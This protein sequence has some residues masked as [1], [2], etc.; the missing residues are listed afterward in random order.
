MEFWVTCHDCLYL[1]RFTEHI[2]NVAAHELLHLTLNGAFQTH[3]GVSMV[4]AA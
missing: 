4:T 3:T 2:A 1:R